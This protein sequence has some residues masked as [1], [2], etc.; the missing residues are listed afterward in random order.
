SD[1]TSST[2]K[3]GGTTSVLSASAG[4]FGGMRGRTAAKSLVWAP[5]RQAGANRGREKT[6]KT[7][8]REQRPRRMGGPRRGRPR[9]EAKIRARKTMSRKLSIFERPWCGFGRAA[10]VEVRLQEYLRRH[11][12]PACLALLV[13]QA[14]VPQLALRLP[15]REAFVVEHARNAGEVRHPR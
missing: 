8:A 3:P 5:L 9:S 10:R 15:R 14:R 1:A 7:R 2:W 6:A 4:S 11:A 13:R 12:V